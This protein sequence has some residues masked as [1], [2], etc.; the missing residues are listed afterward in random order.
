M[1]KF[2]KDN[3]KYKDSNLSI[4]K[5]IE[6]IKVNI[7]KSYRNFKPLQSNITYNSKFKA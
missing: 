2:N 4:Y 1:E 5:N 6:N 3:H 7:S